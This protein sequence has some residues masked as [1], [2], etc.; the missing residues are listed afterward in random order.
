MEMEES[1]TTEPNATDLKG[2]GMGTVVPTIE[3]T[4][5]IKKPVTPTPCS[6]HTVKCITVGVTLGSC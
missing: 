3:S 5:G 4:A 6:H 1:Y 2:C